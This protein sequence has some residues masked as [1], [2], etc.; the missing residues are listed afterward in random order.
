MSARPDGDNG[1]S[2]ALPRLPR[3]LLRLLARDA[4]SEFL[5]GDLEEEFRRRRRSLSFAAVPAVLLVTSAAAC[6]LPALRAARVEP[7]EALRSE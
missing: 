1:G 2:G 3:A 4:D 6:L 5:L 7:V